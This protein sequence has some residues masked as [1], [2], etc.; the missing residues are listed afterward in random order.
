MYEFKIER[1]VGHGPTGGTPR[2]KGVFCRLRARLGVAVGLLVG[3]AAFVP[4]AASAASGTLTSGD[5]TSAAG[6]QHYELY[7]P[8]SYKAGTAMPM[9]VALHGCTQTADGF[10][11]LTRWD[12][13]AEAKGF[14]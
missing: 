10:R 3:V 8:S 12:T 7:V 9:V 4:G 2:R 14:I 13:L 11:L 6:T 5:S 1:A